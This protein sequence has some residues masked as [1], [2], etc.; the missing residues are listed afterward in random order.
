MNVMW[1]VWA[2]PCLAAC[3]IIRIAPLKRK[4]EAGA[5]A[6]LVFGFGIGSKQRVPISYLGCQAILSNYC[7]KALLCLEGLLCSGKRIHQ[8]TE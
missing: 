1:S 6:Y 8:Y 3:N 5:R 7:V 2:L 4:Y